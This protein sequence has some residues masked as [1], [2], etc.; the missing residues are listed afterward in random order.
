MYKFCASDNQLLARTHPPITL[1]DLD[2]YFS[3]RGEEDRADFQHIGITYNIN[4]GVKMMRMAKMT[5]MVTTLFQVQILGP[6]GRGEENQPPPYSTQPRYIFFVKT[7]EA[8]CKG[9]NAT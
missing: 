9:T 5:M 7:E 6:G 3:E 8:C 1:H 4:H 2:I